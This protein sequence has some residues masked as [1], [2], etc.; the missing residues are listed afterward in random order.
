MAYAYILEKYGP[1]DNVRPTPL[2]HPS[3]HWL[4]NEHEP[5][6]W[7]FYIFITWQTLA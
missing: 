4:T 1:K 5:D 7:S 6:L 3:H 2:E